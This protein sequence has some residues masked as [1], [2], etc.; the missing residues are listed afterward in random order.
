[1]DNWQLQ[2]VPSGHFAA[3][4][5]IAWVRSGVTFKEEKSFYPFEEVKQKKQNSYG[6]S[7]EEPS[8]K[9]FM[10]SISCKCYLVS[11]RST[12]KMIL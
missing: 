11:L 8:L 1:M 5:D 9:T 4:T 12:K 6:R 2:K 10:L 7:L 3:V